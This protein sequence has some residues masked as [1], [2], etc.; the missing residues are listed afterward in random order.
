MFRSEVVRFCYLPGMCV[1]YH[2]PPPV[3][4]GREGAH[5]LVGEGVGGPSSYEGT[6]SDRHWY[7]RY[8]CTLC[9]RYAGDALQGEHPLRG[10]G[11]GVHTP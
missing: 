11:A 9:V 7:A 1:R 2:G 4:G 5:S 8:I 3:P 10:E 6:E